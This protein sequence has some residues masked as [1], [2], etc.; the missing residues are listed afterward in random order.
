MAQL[1]NVGIAQ[2]LQFLVPADHARRLQGNRAEN[3][4]RRFDSIDKQLAGNPYL[5]GDKFSVADAHMFTVLRWSPRVNI[6]TSKWPNIKACMDRVAAR[7]KVQ[8]APQGGGTGLD[9]AR[10]SFMSVP[11]ARGSD[12]AHARRC[13]RIADLRPVGKLDVRERASQSTSATRFAG[14]NSLGSGLWRA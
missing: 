4:G 2:E 3:L 12:D 7:P 8:E 5:M 10:M 14:R 1:R 11:R 9:G 6:D 13:D